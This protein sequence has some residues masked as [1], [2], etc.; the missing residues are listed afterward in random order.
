ME[1]ENIEY[2]KKLLKEIE[3]L[4]N[5]LEDVKKGLEKELFIKDEET[6]DY[7]HELE[8]AKLNVSGIMKTTKKLIAT[9]R[10]RRVI[11]DKLEVLNTLKGYA[12][13]YI[14]KGIIAE[15]KQAIS[16]L[17]KLEDNWET[18]S[19]TAKVVKDLKCAKK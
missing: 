18:R 15:T 4:F 17:E 13:R 14:S 1:I 16:N 19:Y 3:N 6:Q 8:L 12:D 11:K 5:N 10:E 9:R 7:L 2:S